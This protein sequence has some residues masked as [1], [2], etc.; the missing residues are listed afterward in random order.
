MEHVKHRIVIDIGA[1]N[2]GDGAI[3]A[4]ITREDRHRTNFYNSISADSVRRLHRL[5]NRLRAEG[6]VVHG[7]RAQSDTQLGATIEIQ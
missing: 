7:A 3:V 4:R 5:C 2:E 1:E 6:R